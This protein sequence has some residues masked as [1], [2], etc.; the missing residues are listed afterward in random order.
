MPPASP[1]LHP[2]VPHRVI[3]AQFE[4]EVSPL[5]GGKDVLQQVRFVDLVPDPGGHRL[6]RLIGEI[7]VAM[8]IRGRVTE[9]RLA[10][11]EEPIDVPATDV[12]DLG[13]DL[14]KNVTR[15]RRS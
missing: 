2:N 6:G 5:P 11:R 12:A 15:A 9:R 14:D 3:G 8:E 4:D 10:Q 1:L 13:V 7:G